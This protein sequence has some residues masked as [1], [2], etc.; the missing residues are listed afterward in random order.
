MANP[1]HLEILRQ[2][3]KVW[4]NWRQENPKIKA[5]LSYA[6][7]RKADLSVA[8][9]SYADL[10]GAY[11][12]YA[13]L[14]GAYLRKANLKEADLSGADLRKANL[15]E[16]DLSGADL[17]GAS[18]SGADLKEADLSGAD[19]TQ[20]QVLYTNLEKNTLTGAC[21]KDWHINTETNLQ[22]IKC[23]Y[24]FFN[25]IWNVQKRK[26]IF[27]ERRPHQEDKFFEAGDFERLVK[28]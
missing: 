22:N 27:T 23:D 3:V 9:L 8:N 25:S 5:D 4:N 28:R 17:S 24:I 18:L 7:I 15:K 6:D 14:S 26:S 20:T 13:D 16:A 1:E 2:G 21:I 19:L 10:S 11:L 12:G